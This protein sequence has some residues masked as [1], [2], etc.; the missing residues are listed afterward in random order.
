M[1][2]SIYFNAQFKQTYVICK[3]ASINMIVCT[4]WETTLDPPSTGS[5]TTTTE[6]RNPQH[7][8]MINVG[9]CCQISET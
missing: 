7:Q 4:G 2:N 8:N 6:N 5:T 3:H 9:L 1:F